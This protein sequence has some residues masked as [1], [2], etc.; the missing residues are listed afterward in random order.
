MN[1]LGR[2]VEYYLR[3]TLLVESVHHDHFTVDDR[4]SHWTAAHPTKRTKQFIN[5]LNNTSINK[6]QLNDVIKMIEIQ[7]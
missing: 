5:S 4:R 7:T 2:K 1:Q 3:K 6:N